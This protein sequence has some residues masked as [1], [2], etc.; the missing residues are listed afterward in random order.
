MRRRA[1]QALL[2]ARRR[3]YA[4]HSPLSAAGLPRAFGTLGRGL[5]RCACA[6]RRQRDHLALCKLSL[7]PKGDRFDL[8]ADRQ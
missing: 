4:L 1:G 5:G 8:V 6:L 3:A 7:A 2:F